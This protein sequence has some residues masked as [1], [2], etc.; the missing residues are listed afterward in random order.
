MSKLLAA[1]CT[2]DGMVKVGN[3]EV[4]AA[5][6]LSAGKQA[7]SGI[8]FIDGDKAWFMPSSAT[9]IGTTIEKLIDVITKAADSITKIGVTLT[10]IGA[11]MTGPTTSPPPTLATDVAALNAN[12]V[13]LN[14]TKSQLDQL[15]GALK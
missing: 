14:A 9:D 6:V 7:S 10:S 15:K 8:L 11:G 4:P 5:M 12:V 13:A 2:A 1:T 3:L